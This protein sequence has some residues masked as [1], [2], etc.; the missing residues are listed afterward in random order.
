MLITFINKNF[1]S[2]GLQISEFYPKIIQINNVITN[3][4]NIINIFVNKNYK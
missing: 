1:K 2:Y 4:N 3:L